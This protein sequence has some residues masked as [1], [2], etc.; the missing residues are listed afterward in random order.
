MYGGT[1]TSMWIWPGPC[2]CLV[3]F[4]ALLVAQLSQ[5]FSDLPS[6]L[7]INFFPSVFWCKNDMGLT[8]VLGMCCALDFVS[9]IF[10]TDYTSY[11]NI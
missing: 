1:L 11:L 3:D 10:F 7:P 5:N 9:Y 4:R 2:L 8:S 6:Q